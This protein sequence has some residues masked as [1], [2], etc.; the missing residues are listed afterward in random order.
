M[1]TTYDENGRP[2]NPETPGTLYWD[3]WQSQHGAEQAA[4]DAVHGSGSTQANNAAQNL[5]INYGTDLGKQK[6]MLEESNRLNPYMSLSNDPDKNLWETGYGGL[7]NPST[8]EVNKASSM[9]SLFKDP[10]PE[11]MLGFSAGE[12]YGEQK[13]RDL[14]S[15]GDA[16]DIWNRLKQESTYGLDAQSMKDIKDKYS[17]QSVKERAMIAKSGLKGQAAFRAGQDLEAQ[18]R[19]E[20]AAVSENI[21]KTAFNNMRDEWGRRSLISLNY[22]IAYGQLGSAAMLGQTQQNLAA[23]DF[24]SLYND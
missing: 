21:K 13:V 16:K 20:A 2:V 18:K 12:N 5:Y 15:S 8:G 22:P 24:N 6:V 3:T 1:A 7:Y 4:W 19:Q 17:G 23:I 14:Y 10:V 9:A 11:G